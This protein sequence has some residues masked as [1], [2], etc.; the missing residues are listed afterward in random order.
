MPYIKRMWINQPSTSQ[1]FHKMHGT[2]VLAIH[3]SFLMMRV[4]FLDGDIISQQI[5]TMALSMGWPKH[6]QI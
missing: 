1:E 3:E 5:P 2:R 6:E 4:Y